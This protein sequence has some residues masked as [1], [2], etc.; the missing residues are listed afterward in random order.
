MGLVKNEYNRDTLCRMETG[1]G[2]SKKGQ[3]ENVRG[4]LGE[5]THKEE[6]CTD[7]EEGV[8]KCHFQSGWKDTGL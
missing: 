7:I 1:E 2:D 6:G 3:P 5:E 4:C 8:F